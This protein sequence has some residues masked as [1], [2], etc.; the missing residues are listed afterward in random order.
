M[1]RQGDGWVACHAFA[2]TRCEIIQCVRE[3][4]V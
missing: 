1:Q 2:A 3:K 4:L